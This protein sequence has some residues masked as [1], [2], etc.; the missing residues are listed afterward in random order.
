MQKLFYLLGAIAILASTAYLFSHRAPVDGISEEVLMNFNSFK[1][2]YGKHY[3]A[4]EEVYRLTVFNEN[5]LMIQHFNTH[6]SKKEGFEMGVNQF[7]D[8]K[9]EEFRAIYLG[10]KSNGKRTGLPQPEEVLSQ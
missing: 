1:V 2:Q 4:V 8:L 9:N 7:A 10:Y 5:Y 6:E 3:D